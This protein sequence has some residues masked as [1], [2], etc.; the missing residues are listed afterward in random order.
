[1]NTI[2]A[3]AFCVV[4]ATGAFVFVRA[5]AFLDALLMRADPAC[6]ELAAADNERLAEAIAPYLPSVRHDDIEGGHGCQPPETGAWVEIE[7]NGMSIESAL[8][9]FNPPTWTRLPEAEVRVQIAPDENSAT[10]IGKVGDREVNVS[11][12]QVRSGKGPVTVMAW[13]TGEK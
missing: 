6:I 9:G 12:Y 13:Y 2:V 11:A 10:V 1:M 7:L 5:E 4:V 3:M 8:R